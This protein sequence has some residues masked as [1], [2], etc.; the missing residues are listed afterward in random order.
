MA[1][2]RTRWKE[3]FTK[4][5]GP[6]WPCPRC[7]RSLNL[8]KESVRIAETVNSR[9]SRHS[10]DWDPDSL[11]E[12]FVCLLKCSSTACAEPVSILGYT[13]Y[14]PAYD[15][16]GHIEWDQRLHAKFVFP[17]PDF[18][19]LPRRCPSKVSEEVRRAFALFWAD[20]EAAANRVRTSVEYLLDS[21]GIQK[22]QK[23]AGGKMRK[24]NLHERIVLFQKVQPAVG[25]QLLAIK[26][27]GNAGSHPE[28]L[29]D[30]DLFDAFEMLSHALEEIIEKRTERVARLASEI[31]KRK[32][33]RS[34]KRG[35]RR[36]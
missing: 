27:I 33:P 19:A 17:A 4:D 21:L 14:E 24:L 34:S 1:I 35:K 2:E 18:F 31:N 8:D 12:R 16:A 3:S 15:E 36:A 20:R 13:T 5:Y 30:D 10:E 26:W 22:S 29:S 9:T 11:E 7:K 25:A 28:E 32:A 6:N 23:T